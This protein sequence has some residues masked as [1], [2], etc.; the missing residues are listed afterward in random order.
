MLKIATINTNVGTTFSIRNSWRTQ[1][2]KHLN[3]DEELFPFNFQITSIVNDEYVCESI[4]DGK[5]KKK[6]NIIVDPIIVQYL[7]GIEVDDVNVGLYFHDYLPMEN[8]KLLICNYKNNTIMPAQFKFS[9]EMI[10]NAPKLT[11]ILNDLLTGEIY[12]VASQIKNSWKLLSGADSYMTDIEKMYQD[13]F[14]HKGYVMQVCSKFAEYLREQGL[15]DDANK[16]MERAVVH[17]NSKIVNKDEF[18]ALTSI[19]NDKSCLGNAKAQL[20]MFKQDSIELHWKH[21]AHHP[22]HFTNYDEMSRIDRIEMVCD[23][24]ARSMQYKSDLLQFVETR[25][26]ER[27][28]FSELMYDEVYHYCK[29]LTSLFAN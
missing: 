3:K 26:N 8:S 23:W 16:L 1:I 5:S 7:N 17:D 12:A 27:F 11:F 20:S 4:P 21:N 28:H 6:Y 13:T 10:D 25:Q 22:E 29:I 2:A 14:V 18:R 19:I 9:I 15:E 24:M